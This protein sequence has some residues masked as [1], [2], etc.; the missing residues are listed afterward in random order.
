[1]YS[2]QVVQ[3]MLQGAI[4]RIMN[5]E[6]LPPALFGT[7]MR[8]EISSMRSQEGHLRRI[9]IWWIVLVQNFS[10]SHLDWLADTLKQAKRRLDAE[11]H[12]ICFQLLFDHVF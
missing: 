4:T 2:P 7:W 12:F 6:F 3:R 11:D 1:M 8:K 10:L 9:E 5:V